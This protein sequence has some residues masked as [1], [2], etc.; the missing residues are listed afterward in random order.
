MRLLRYPLRGVLALLVG[1]VAGFWWLGGDEAQRWPR[2]KRPRDRARRRPVVIDGTL[3]VELGTAPMLQLTGLRID[4]PS[5]AKHRLCCGSSAPR[6]RS[7][8]AL[9]SS[10][11]SCCHVSSFRG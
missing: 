8:F 5:W 1:G 9:C 4:N 7:R 11:W 10:A 2:P 3:E 6:C